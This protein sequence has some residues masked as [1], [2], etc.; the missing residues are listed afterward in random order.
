M[1]STP[2]ILLSKRSGLSSDRPSGTILQGGEL[3]LCFG[4]A[5]PGLYFEDSAGAVRK[6]GPAGYGTT[7]PN[8]S[9]AG[10]A[11]N[12]VGELWTDNNGATRYLKVWT[13]GAWVKID[14]GFADS[15][16]SAGFAS[17]AIIASGAVLASGSIRS[18]TVVL[19]GLPTPTSFPSGA[20][21]YQIQPSGAFSAGLYV[22]AT[23]TWLLT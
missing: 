2:V 9:P 3:A 15:A 20:L 5:D 18:S 11:G 22:R 14:A 17:T 23:N 21:F 19:S 4:A 10:L 6:I 16:T 13:G 7:A 1:T 8:S 12:S